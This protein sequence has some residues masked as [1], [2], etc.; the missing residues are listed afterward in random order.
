MKATRAKEYA[1]HFEHMESSL[2]GLPEWPSS[3]VVRQA[4]LEII[5]ACI[6]LQSENSGADSAR[7]GALC[8]HVDPRTGRMGEGVFLNSPSERGPRYRAHPGSNISFCDKALPLWEEA[9][10]VACKAAAAFPIAH[11]I[12]WNVA[13]SA[14]GAVLLDGNRAQHVAHRDG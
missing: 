10:A 9:A 4:D 11:G 3:P 8:V 5:H 1:D 14:R 13:L 7:T 2:K 6:P 12:Q